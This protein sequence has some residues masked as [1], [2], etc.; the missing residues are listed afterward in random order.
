MRRGLA[1]RLILSLVF[2][3]LAAGIAAQS[4]PVPQAIEALAAPQAIAPALP[5]T[6]AVTS[7]VPQP[8]SAFRASAPPFDPRYESSSQH[9]HGVPDDPASLALLPGHILRDQ[10]RMWLAPLRIRGQHAPWLAA[11]AGITAG[12]FAVDARVQRRLTYEE[13][14]AGYAFASNFGRFSGGEMDLAVAGGFY[15][16]GSWSGNVRAQ[17]TG[18]LG[19]RAVIDVMILNKSMKMIAR[20]R[21]PAMDDG[22][23]NHG[24]TGEFFESGRSFPSGHSAEAWALAAVV[25]HQYSHRKWV[26]ALAYGL[27]GLVAASRIP[28]RKHFPSDVLVGSVLGFTAG[29]SVWRSAHPERGEPRNL[30]ILPYAPQGGGFGVALGLGF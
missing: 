8:V 10:Q 25:V 20:R 6:N 3:P 22:A 21:R 11:T 15:L 16:A 9:Q 27:A 5:A 19:L 2:G 1:V 28:A 13:P 26:P 4:Q 29:R 17:E 12:L 14:G 24:A 7:S 23:P 18:V 30:Q